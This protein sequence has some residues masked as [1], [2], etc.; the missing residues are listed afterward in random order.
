MKITLLAVG[1]RMDAWV[2]A[3]VEEYARRLRG[4][5]DFRVCEVPLARRGKSVGV[6]QLMQKEG[7]ALLERIP[8]GDH[9]V[10]LEVDGR[11]LDT[12]AFAARLAQ[13]RDSS[14]NL[15]LLAGGPDGLAPA[16]RERADEAWSLSALT[17]PHP[18]VRI[19]VAEQLYRAFSLLKGHPYHRE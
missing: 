9:V 10:A 5:V 12:G 15:C 2:E 8:Q 13:L 11:S 14:R 6:E 7:R 1:S 16:C 18:L 19:I 4:T 3:G 17:L